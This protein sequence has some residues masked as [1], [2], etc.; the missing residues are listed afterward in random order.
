MSMCEWR[1]EVWK[2][3]EEGDFVKICWIFRLDILNV[4]IVFGCWS[5]C[6]FGYVVCIW[7]EFWVCRCVVVRVCDW[8]FGFG[9]DVCEVVICGEVINGMIE[10]SGVGVVKIIGDIV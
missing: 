6:V 9:C 10:V 3:W 2:F 8:E 5:C 1:V 7:I 4:C